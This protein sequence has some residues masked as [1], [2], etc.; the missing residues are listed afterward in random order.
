MKKHIDKDHQ[1]EEEIES[2]ARKEA[3]TNNPDDRIEHEEDDIEEEDDE[4]ITEEKSDKD[5]INELKTRVENTNRRIYNMEMENVNLFKEKTYFN[6]QTEQAAKYVTSL[7]IGFKKTHEEL[8][9]KLYEKD[10]VINAMKQEIDQYKA[11]KLITVPS[12][13]EEQRP[14][15]SAETPTLVTSLPAPNIVPNIWRPFEDSQLDECI[16]N[17]RCEG[18]CD[19]T[20]A[21]KS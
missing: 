8:I 2:P 1:V 4:N 13:V 19:Q 20:F 11:L 17:I 16:E 14:N 10:T 3:K 21:D 18:N 12:P 9:N 5:L 7:N 6:D 15:N